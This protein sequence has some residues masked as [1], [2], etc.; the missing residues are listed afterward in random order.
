MFN[1]P[2]IC[3]ALI[4]ELLYLPIF[5]YGTIYWGVVVSSPQASA[6]GGCGSGQGYVRGNCGQAP[7]IQRNNRIGSTQNQ[8]SLEQYPREQEQQ[9]S[10]EQSLEIS[11][12]LPVCLH[13]PFF[14][15]VTKGPLAVRDQS[16][17]IG[18]RP[19]CGQKK[20][21]TTWPRCP[22]Y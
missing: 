12:N 16:S 4:R 6:N 5:E 21:R 11:C 3:M 17:K 20:S 18:N 8:Q 7:G 2:E 10:E 1:R 15:S 22:A 13:T 9:M 19:S 14:R